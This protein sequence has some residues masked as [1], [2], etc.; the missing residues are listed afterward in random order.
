MLQNFRRLHKKR[1]RESSSHYGNES[2]I[3]RRSWKTRMNPRP[4]KYFRSRSKSNSSLRRATQSA[5]KRMGLQA[6]YEEI[7]RHLVD[8]VNWRWSGY[9]RRLA[10]RK[11][12]STFLK[13]TA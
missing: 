3:S 10:S 12:G 1:Y 13:A 9:L 5:I 2:K 6:P 7:L 8:G 11:A 4:A